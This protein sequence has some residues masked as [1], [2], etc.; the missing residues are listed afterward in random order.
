MKFKELSGYIEQ[1]EKTKSRLTITQLLSDLYKKLSPVEIEKTTYLLQGRVVPLFEKLEFS[2]AEKTV[3]KTVSLALNLERTLFEHEY[4][5]IG[6]LGLTVE[7]F[8]K[9]I[10]LFDEKDLTITEVYDSLLTLAKLSGTGSQEKKIQILAGLIRQLDHLST[11]Y[12]V[13]IPIGVLRLGFSDMTVLDAF[14]WMIGGDKTL[15]KLIEQA[16][17]VRPDLGLLGKILKE[18][19]MKGIKS[20]KP[21]IFTPILMMRAERL[22]SGREIIDTIGRCAVQQKFDGFRLQVHYVKKTH[23]VRLYSRN[24]EEVSSMYPDIIEGIKKEIKGNEIIFEGEAIGFD[25]LTGNFLPFQETVQ[26]KRKYDIEE[27][28]K[29]IPLKLFAFELLYCNG[30]SYLNTSYKERRKI[31]EK[32]IVAPENA[33]K[34]TVILAPEKVLDSEKDIEIEF[35]DAISKGLEGIIA[36]KL[37]GIYQAG[38]RGWNWI[39]FKRSYSSKIEDTIDCLVMGYD[40]GKGKRTSFGI[41]AFLVGVF[42][43]EKDSFVTVAKIGTGLTDEEWKTLKIKAQKSKSK[44]KPNQYNVDKQMNVDVWIEPS[45]V[46]EIRADEISRSPVHTAKLALRFPRLERFRKDKR[47]D[48]A[49]S[50]KELET[51]FRKQEK[52]SR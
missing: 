49:T 33:V 8:K 16:Y 34:N 4:K 38:A 18:K 45:I 24:L 14:S 19:G 20:I 25:P 6:D 7:Y 21:E 12:L 35:Q 27:K 48:D 22:S 26:R 47:P 28:A 13:R 37:T 46:V 36:K 42:D 23:E 5:K 40:Y 17:H 30:V 52:K 50:L 32:S 3:I 29:E 51:M 10:R 31:L 15:R 11:R 44:D 43:E 2:L 41:G 9:E 1:I 39:K